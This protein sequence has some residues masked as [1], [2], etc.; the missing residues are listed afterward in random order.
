MLLHRPRSYTSPYF[1]YNYDY[2]CYGT[3]FCSF[4]HAAVARNLQS[5]LQFSPSITAMYGNNAIYCQYRRFWRNVTWF[6]YHACSYLDHAHQIA[7]L[8]FLLTLHDRKIWDQGD[9]KTN[10][11]FYVKFTINKRKVSSLLMSFSYNNDWNNHRKHEY[12]M[13]IYLLQKIIMTPYSVHV[14]WPWGFNVMLL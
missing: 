8:V 13:S 12:W 9:P 14:G 3:K 4:M 7:W 2:F 1:L 5:L 10:S 11:R 6:E